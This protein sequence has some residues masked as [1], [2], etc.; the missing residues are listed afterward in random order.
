ASGRRVRGAELPLGL[1]WRGRGQQGSYHLVKQGNGQDPPQQGEATEGEIALA[2]RRQPGAQQQIVEGTVL[3]RAGEV[4]ENLV[5]RAR[6][7]EDGI[8]LV[9]PQALRCE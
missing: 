6:G 5:Q 8:H 9:A 1:A 7:E 3:S 4:A 2:G